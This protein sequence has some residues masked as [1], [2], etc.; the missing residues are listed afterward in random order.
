MSDG[1]I[2]YRTM[3][4]KDKLGAWDLTSV[5]GEITLVISKVERGTVGYGKN[6]KNKP[7]IYFQ[8]VKSGKPLSANVTNCKVIAAMYNTTDVREWVGK[9]VTLYAAKTEMGGEIVDCIRIR[10]TVPQRKGQPAQEPSE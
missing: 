2:D 10:P 5:G 6:K 8:G 3:M 9:A 4:D 7:D 1:P